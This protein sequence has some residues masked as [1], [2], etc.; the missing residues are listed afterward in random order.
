M[1]QMKMGVD[2]IEVA[3]YQAG[4]HADQPCV[5]LTF[6]GCAEHKMHVDAARHLAARLLHASRFAEAGGE[7]DVPHAEH[8][9]AWIITITDLGGAALEE[10]R[11]QVEAKLAK[12]ADVSPD[13]QQ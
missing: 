10:V 2:D 11:R 3:A 1:E 4:E 9:L 6:P 7:V 12:C 8:D 13:G 5:K